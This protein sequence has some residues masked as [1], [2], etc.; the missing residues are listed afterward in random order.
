MKKVI[1]V[2]SDFGYGQDLMY[3]E[4][5]FN[6]IYALNNEFRVDLNK[7]KGEKNLSLPFALGILEG[8]HLKRSR[9]VGTADYDSSIFIPTFSSIFKIFKEK[10][11]VIITIEFTPISCILI[12]LS[13]LLKIKCN[14]L[15]VESDPELRG[16]KTKGLV[17]LIKRSIAGMVHAVQTNT[18]EG[19]NFIENKLKVEPCR[20]HQS[21]YLTSQLKLSSTPLIKSQKITIAFCNS[22]IE[23]KGL[24]VLVDALLLLNKNER[25]SIKL[26]VVG[27]GNLINY[28]KKSLG[29]DFEVEYFGKLKFNK[30]GDALSDADIYVSPS[31][32]DYRSLGTFEALSLGLAIIGTIEDGATRET[33][34][35]GKNGFII[36]ANDAKLLSDKIR[37]FITNKPKIEE[38]KNYSRNLFVER[39]FASYQ[40]AEN[41]HRVCLHTF[42]AREKK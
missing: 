33:I 4:D 11:D 15:F 8:Y 28:A 38:F 30:I 1:L 27:D 5:I 2:S 10:P 3:Y 23:R 35:D 6:E 42:Y 40:V 17:L 21:P 39:R 20:I 37:F 25:K 7:D 13:K 14:I 22:A 26:K 9:K 34:F 29:E 24:H 31:L 19:K 16:G 12:L 36:S 18:S 32:A 41:I